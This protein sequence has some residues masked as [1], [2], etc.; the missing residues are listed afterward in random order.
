[1]RLFKRY[2]MLFSAYSVS[3]TTLCNVEGEPRWSGILQWRINLRYAT[4]RGK[5][6]TLEHKEGVYDLA[7]RG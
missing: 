5:K 3:Q 1:M 6:F 4:M 2:V 7:K